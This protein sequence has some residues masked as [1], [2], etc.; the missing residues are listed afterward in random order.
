M[1]A[2]RFAAPWS[3]RLKAVTGLAT[4]A[5]L[6][7]SFGLF[8]KGEPWLAGFLLLVWVHSVAGHVKGYAVEGSTLHIERLLRRHRIELSGL[9]TVEPRPGLLRGSIRLGNGGLFSFAGWFFNFRERWMRVVATDLGDRTVMVVVD[10]VKWVVSPEDPA[11]FSSA[12]R[13]AAGLER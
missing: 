1:T 12:V 4:A 2:Q 6:G 7:G 10:G 3:L 13:R 5:I 9:T 11:G 8:D